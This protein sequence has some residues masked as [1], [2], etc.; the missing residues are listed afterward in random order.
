MYVYPSIKHLLAQYHG[1]AN[2]RI[3]REHLQ[4]NLQ[5]L[6]WGRHIETGNLQEAPGN[7]N[8]PTMLQFTHH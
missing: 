7:P 4:G 6:Q 8:H 5:G 1:S 2:L 3:L